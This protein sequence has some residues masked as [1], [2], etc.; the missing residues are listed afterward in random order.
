MGRKKKSRHKWYFTIP[1]P[2]GRKV[3]SPQCRQVKTGHSHL[4]LSLGTNKWISKGKNT[5]LLSFVCLALLLGLLPWNTW[6]DQWRSSASS[7]DDSWCSQLRRKAAG[8]SILPAFSPSRAAGLIGSSCKW[9]IGI[10]T[11]E[12]WKINLGKWYERRQIHWV[13]LAKMC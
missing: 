11:T 8:R 6:R 2:A 4:V 13:L 12:K 7:M 5:G 9:G 1:F 3:R 10:V